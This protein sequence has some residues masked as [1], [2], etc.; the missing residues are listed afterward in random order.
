[1]IKAEKLS[2]AYTVGAVRP[3]RAT[4][5]D[6]LTAA[7][8][9]PF[10]RFRGKGSPRAETI[11]ALKNVSLEIPRGDVVGIIG[12]NGAGKST[13]LK[14]FSRVTEPTGGVVDLYGRVA[15]LLEVGT[16]FHHELTGR[17]NVYLNSAIL[18]MKR[19]EIDKRFD[20]I[21][22][23]AEVEK[24][25]DTPV[26]YYSSGMYMRLAF[27]V[28]AHLESEILIVD[29]VLAVGDAAF[30]KKCL[31]KMDDAAKTGRTVVFVS[32]DLGAVGRLCHS[33]IWLEQGEVAYAG[34][35]KECIACYLTTAAPVCSRREWP[36]PAS[37][38]GDEYLR[39]LS[40]EVLDEA[41]RPLQALHQDESFVVRMVYQVLKPMKNA[42]VGF[43]LKANN[44]TVIFASYDC[45][46]PDWNGRG[47]R[48]GVF[49]A[50]CIVP[51]NFLNEGT[52]FLTLTGGI[53][54]IKLCLHAEDVISLKISGALTDQSAVGRMNAPRLGVVA[55][56]LEWQVCM[57]ER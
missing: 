7:F 21:V 18:G 34:K 28:A 48:P 50:E 37:A 5:R 40:V 35:V 55:P 39:V 54:F 32:H 10:N 2:K 51:A 41:R 24:F 33:A 8:R 26:K 23:F 3:D 22:A 47:R 1:M 11:W 36:E 14:V 31:G 53:P 52:Y 57:L 20:A 45:D 16:G 17:E 12:R 29:E 19:K 13:L 30:Q 38:P 6:S 44:G 15:S 49:S 27:A 46:N 25:I 43:H 4:L 9:A 42:N 56:N